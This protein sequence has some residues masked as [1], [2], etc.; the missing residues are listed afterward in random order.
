VKHILLIA[1]TGAVTIP[2]GLVLLAVGPVAWPLGLLGGWL[3][4]AWTQ[5]VRHRHD[6]AWGTFRVW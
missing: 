3:L 6:P 4:W 2:F 1:L 5:A